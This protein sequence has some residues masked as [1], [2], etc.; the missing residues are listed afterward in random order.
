MEDMQ[1]ATTLF[2][3]SFRQR[4]EI[5]E[6]LASAGAGA[7][8]QAAVVGDAEGLESRFL[9]SGAAV[10]LIDARGA[11]DDGLSA[12]RRLGGL[13]ATNGAA[14]LVLVS[15][16]DVEAIGEFF[17]AGATQFLASPA[18]EG[19]LVQALRFAGRHAAR[20]SGG[21]IDRRGIPGASHYDRETG[22]ARRWIV[23]RIAEER[24]VAVVLVALS[25]L[26]IV[27]A[28]H[29]RPAVDG[30]IEAAVLRAETVARQ[31][32]GVDAMVA[33]LGGSEFVLVIEAAGA[34]VTA[35]ITA[36]DAAL[37]RPFA[38]ADTR[39]VLGCRFGVA[40]RQPGDDAA[41]LLRRASEALAEAKASDGSVLHVALP[42]GVAPIDALAIDLHHAIERDEIDLRWQPQVEIASGK[43]TGVEAL[44]RWNHRALGPLGA[45]TLFDAA[46]RA[47]LGIALSDHIQRLV[48]A[49]AVAWPEVLGTLRVS[50]NLTA[51]DITRPGFAALFLARIDESGFPRGRLTVE[52]TETG[53]IEDLAAA[54]ALL[55][56][57]RGAGCRVAIDDFGTGYS[58]LAYLK[59]LPLDYVK[60][61]KSLVRDIDGS[62][63][64]RVVVAGA[65]TMARS[66]GLAVIAEGVERPSQL[67]LLAA[68]GCSLY[69]GFLLSEPVG[70]A[71][72]LE[73]M[74]RE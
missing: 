5:T 36:L 58:S 11:L 7:G 63:R 13:V 57:L 10:A 64:D 67:E 68:G 45:D 21:A 16:G 65:I 6:I 27:N 38:V 9:G 28:A 12:T 3:V 35:A 66:L 53:L 60:I 25:R 22:E 42:D 14:L 72:L 40:Q 49:R 44:A 1:I 31:A 26:D 46:D 50:L 55:A 30:L 43:I 62:A 69:Q 51:A 8:W 47:D 39:A 74:A 17:D 23:S 71:A 48:L 32:I 19:E 4:D 52:I 18:S 61:D 29:G 54:S 15:R 2:A 70:E 24:P 73:L 59:S 34:A 56:E 37:A 33:R 41:A 20:A